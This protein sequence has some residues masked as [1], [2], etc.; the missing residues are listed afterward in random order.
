M[1]KARTAGPAVPTGNSALGGRWA[2][3]P[4]PA[5]VS[6]CVNLWLKKTEDM[7]GFWLAARGTAAYNQPQYRQ[8]G[9]TILS[10]TPGQ[11]TKGS[12]V[13]RLTTWSMLLAAGLFVGSAALTVVV[14]DEA[15]TKETGTVIGKVID[16]NGKPVKTTNVAIIVP[17]DPSSK[18][19]VV[20]AVGAPPKRT[21]IV[22][23]GATNDDGTFKIENVPVG[24]YVVSVH[25]DKSLRP[26]HSKELEVK[27][28]EAV[29]A[30]TITLAIR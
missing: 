26:G 11:S 12:S 19:N 4:Y 2:S 6:I 3:R 28:K 13:M 29:D 10:G 27:A 21:P 7:V 23:H 25:A 24:K 16:S 8:L 14:A 9:E 18:T 30:G 20:A 17:L 22:A 5:L 1:K 15:P